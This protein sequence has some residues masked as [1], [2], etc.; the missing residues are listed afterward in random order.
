LAADTAARYC[1]A[2]IKQAWAM[3]QRALADVDEFL[4]GDHEHGEAPWWRRALRFVALTCRSF[5]RNRCPVRAS[6]LAYMTLLALIPLLAV[7]ISVSA[8]LIKAQNDADRAMR[9]GLMVDKFVGNIAPQLNLRMTGGPEGE[10]NREQ[11]VQRVNEFIANTQSGKLGAT[12][13]IGLVVVAI[14]LLSNIE[15][16]FN[17]IW[18]VDKGRNWF[19]RVIN[20]WAAITLGPILFAVVVGLAT[21]T[22]FQATQD[23]IRNSGFLGRLLFNGIP[24]LIPCVAFTVF[25]KLMPNTRVLWSAALVGGV[26]GGLLWQANNL[27]NVVYLKN[28]TTYSH[29][30]GGL[31]TIPIFLLGLYFSWL[32]LLLGAQIGYAF[33]NREIYFQE[34]QAENVNQRGREFVALRV[35]TALAQHF[36]AGR[37]P[38]TVVD[39]SKELAVPGRLV[40]QILSA[41]VRARLVQETGREG[42]AFSPARPLEAITV[43]DVLDAHRTANG[44]ELA[45][46][47]DATRKVLRAEVE[48]VRAAERALAGTLTLKELAGKHSAT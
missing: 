3:I 25:Y 29:I 40:T 5:V 48:R 10:Q 43:Q 19:L 22:Q 7:A 13:M 15:A 1:R 6:A 23:F 11:V 36:A 18:G 31:A 37:K 46:A 35:M 14:L 33:Q 47:D 26:F 28:V 9:I 12:G 44:R 16:T 21:S 8:S 24:F 20:Y 34:R 42:G 45:T 39:L 41:M 32:I 4:I 2:V 30:Y 38:P 27:F 17:D